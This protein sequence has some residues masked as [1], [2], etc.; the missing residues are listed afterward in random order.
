M[1]CFDCSVDTWRRAASCSSRPTATL[2]LAGYPVENSITDLTR[3]RTTELELAT[4]KLVMRL[5]TIPARA[6]GAFH[7]PPRRGSA[8][9]REVGGL[10][11][12]FK[13]RGWDDHQDVFGFVM[14]EPIQNRA[15]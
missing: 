10:R 4:R 2:F 1:L 9:V 12:Y 8:R 5:R 14:K 6:I 11:V 13:A 7:L 15:R 3:N